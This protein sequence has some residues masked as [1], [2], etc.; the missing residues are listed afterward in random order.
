VEHPAILFL[1]LEKVGSTL[2]EMVSQNAEKFHLED[3]RFSLKKVGEKIDIF[4]SAAP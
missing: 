1:S 3:R 2:Y 4:S